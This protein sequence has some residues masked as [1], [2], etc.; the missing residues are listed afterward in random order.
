MS[1][2]ENLFMCLLAICMSS[3]E[4]CL[5]RSFAHFFGLIVFDIE[6]HELFVNF[7]KNI[8]ISFFHM[9]LS[10]FL[11]PLTEETVF[12]PLY[13]LASFVID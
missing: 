8:I 11:A 12:S 7:V 2:V 13:S 6:T 10:S 4:T 1:D 5:F 9:E 3:L